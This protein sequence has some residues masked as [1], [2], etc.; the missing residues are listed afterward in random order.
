MIAASCFALIA[1]LVGNVNFSS[2]LQ[3][4]YVPGVGEI[5]II[6]GALFGAGL[7]IYGL[8]LTLLKYLWVILVHYH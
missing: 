7:D 5:A 4:N 2:Y 6:L 8:T 1:Y 3:L